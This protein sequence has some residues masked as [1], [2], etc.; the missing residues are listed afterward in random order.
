MKA[1]DAG[2]VLVWDNDEGALSWICGLVR[3]YAAEYD[4]EGHDTWTREGYIEFTLAERLSQAFYE[5]YDQ[6]LFFAESGTTDLERATTHTACDYVRTG[7]TWRVT[8]CARRRR[9]RR[10]VGIS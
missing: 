1:P 2:I 4:N 9:T 10:S 6:V 8:T 7:T 3:Q 5:D